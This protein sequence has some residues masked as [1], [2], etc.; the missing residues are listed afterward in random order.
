MCNQLQNYKRVS[1]IMS[2]MFQICN[3]VF[4]LFLKTGLGM[5]I[6][7]QCEDISNIEHYVVQSL[8]RSCLYKR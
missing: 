6:G 8:I 4:K 1:R 2:S 3:T 7:H 5:F